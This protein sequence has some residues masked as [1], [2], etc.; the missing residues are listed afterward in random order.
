MKEI[1]YVNGAFCD[2]AEA[3][4]S[5]EDRGFQFADGVYEVIVAP[6]GRPFR[7][8]QHLER[9][10]RSTDAIGLE[11]DYAR[12][13]LPGIIARGIELA[14]FPDT[15]I[16]IQLTRG[17]MSRDHLYQPGLVPTIVA[18]FKVKPPQ[19]P[20]RRRVGLSLETVHDFR[21]EKCHIKSVALLANV[22]V[23]NAARSRGFFDGL[24]VSAEGW[25]R[26][27][28]SAN[29][30]MVA[31]GRL[32]TPPANERILHGVTR[33]YILECAHDIDLPCDEC[34]FTVPELVAADEAF[35]SS[36]T[37]DI[38]PV[39]R[40]DGRPIGKGTPG[41]VSARLLEQFYAG[42]R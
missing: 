20:E 33:G 21:W 26:E 19:D 2:L 41:P 36:T 39:T 14:G 42:M 25:V 17:V 3:R 38:M 40:L 32:K 11:I 16:Y 27:T 9:L 24:M 10:R 13:D 6:G 4:I 18:T 37:M 28:T 34:E 31:G 5:I 1:A 29:I 8:A 12:L 23:K 7:L 30:F 22:M 35:L 15:M